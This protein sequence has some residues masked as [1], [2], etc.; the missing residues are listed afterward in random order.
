[1]SKLYKEIVV[2][3][4]IDDEQVIKYNCFEVLGEDKYCVQSADYYYLSTNNQDRL[5]FEEQF[6]ELLIEVAPD[7]RSQ[8]YDSLEEAIESFD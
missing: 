5:A 4:R 3:K 2:W 7:E 8:L 1:M 6:L